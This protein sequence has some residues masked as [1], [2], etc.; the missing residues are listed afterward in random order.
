MRGKI[1]PKKTKKTDFKK[2]W[3]YSKTAPRFG[4]FKLINITIAEELKKLVFDMLGEEGAK[5]ARKEMRAR[6]YAEKVI[7]SEIV[8]DSLFDVLSE[9]GIIKEMSKETRVTVSEMLRHLSDSIREM[10]SRLTGTGTWRIELRD[11]ATNYR[12]LSNMFMNAMDTAADD[13]QR[14]ELV[15]DIRGEV[16]YSIKYTTD[17]K[18]VVVVTENIL[19]GVPESEWVKT[20]K[21]TIRNKFPNGIPIS[22]R[23]IKVNGITR[24]EFTNSKYSKHLKSNDKIIYKDKF[25]AANNLDEIV[26]ASTNYINEDL[27]HSRKDR[28]VEFARGDVLLRIGESDYAAKVIVGFTSGKQML[29]YDIVDFTKTVFT[30]KNK[31]SSID[32][33]ENRNLRSELSS[34]NT[35]SQNK[36]I[37]NTSISENSENDSTKRYSFKKTKSG[38]ANDAL[39]PYDAEMTGLIENGGNIIVDSYDKLVDAVNRAFE[40]PNDKGTM[41]FGILDNDVLSAINKKIPNLPTEANGSIFKPGRQYSVAATFDS[42][43]H[44]VAD[45]GGLTRE[46]VIDYLDRFA[47][48]IVDN[49]TATF[50]YY[51]RGNL[52]INGILF[53][54]AYQDGTILNFDLVSNKKKIVG[55]QT[56]YM[57]KAD[58]KKRKSAETL[59]MQNA[60]THTSKTQVGQT[61]L[62]NDNT[63]SD[64]SQEVSFD[65]KQSKKKEPSKALKAEDVFGKD[66]KAEFEDLKEDIKNLK[67][68]LAAL[69]VE[70]I[71]P[72]EE[73][74]ERRGY[75]NTILKNK[76]ARFKRIKNLQAILAQTQKARADTSRYAKLF[77]DNFQAVKKTG[78]Y[79]AT[80]E[81]W[82]IMKTVSEITDTYE[83]VVSDFATKAG[84][85]KLQKEHKQIYDAF[86]AY[87]QDK[88]YIR[89]FNLSEYKS[90]LEK[91]AKEYKAEGADIS[92]LAAELK[93]AVEIYLNKAA[94]KQPSY[95]ALVREFDVILSDITEKSEKLADKSEWAQKIKG[96]TVKLAGDQYR[97]VIDTFGSLAEAN[98]YMN[99]AVKF[100]LMLVFCPNTDFYWIP[101]G[102]RQ[103]KSEEKRKNM[104]N[105]RL[106]FILLHIYA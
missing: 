85:A 33:G 10:L 2:N 13:V 82:E 53:K 86:M 69:K 61:F 93:N 8:A 87:A 59:L 74:K 57:K 22:G 104:G 58:Y 102:P 63:F 55:L 94:D 44:L 14:A 15:E 75:L 95:E 50:N 45:K 42:I 21:D 49:D 26:L 91:L 92:G 47:D 5:K 66:Y 89:P 83:P 32:F 6:G 78:S 35:I 43:R 62:T 65:K 84:L 60:S 98:R 70:E 40:N 29:L 77:L 25:K 105:I 79:R 96:Q 68:L 20:V 90:V 81:N 7:D 97:N 56:L 72:S 101:S 34:G 19:D 100:S 9:K 41:Y 16:R 99:G 3:T 23:L 106:Y 24:S 11:K 46:D 18:P 71:M 28:I 1:R 52:K 51:I 103:W 88:A 31:D 39:L 30:I 54:K 27:N 48:T 36:G 17:N 4:A 38:M 64:K 76:R 80:G 37:V 67:N 73:V 12:H